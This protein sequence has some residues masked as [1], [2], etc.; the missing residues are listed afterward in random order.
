MENPIQPNGGTLIF[1]CAGAAYP[2]Q[3]SN[4]A[5]VRLHRDNFG[6][7][8]CIAAVAAAIP[9]K[10]ERARNAAVRVAID[11]CEDHCCRII[12]QNAGLPVDVQVTATD[13]GVQ[14][15]PD[16]P[17]MAEDSARIVNAVKQAL[18]V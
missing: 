12:L 8:F 14:K 9:D 4:Q 13:L 5:G 3:A 2:G 18:T 6:N 17:Q 7:L 15:K 10:L 11:G 1:T 16:T